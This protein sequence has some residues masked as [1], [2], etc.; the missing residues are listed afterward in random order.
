MALADINGSS[1]ICCAVNSFDRK[2]LQ[3]VKTSTQCLFRQADANTL[4]QR[5]SKF[6]GLNSSDYNRRSFSFH[7]VRV[8]DQVGDKRFP[9]IIYLSP[10]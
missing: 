2:E 6:E 1:R 8:G 10:M 9:E 5:L 3:K 7:C 4:Y